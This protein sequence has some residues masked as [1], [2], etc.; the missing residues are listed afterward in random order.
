MPTKTGSC[1][2]CGALVWSDSPRCRL[3]AD[4]FRRRWETAECERCGRSFERLI[5]LGRRFC[6]A[7]CR[8][9]AVSEK[10]NMAKHGY[11]G[12]G[13]VRICE[14]CGTSHRCPPSSANRRYCSNECA[15]EARS[16]SGHH[17]WRG[18]VSSKRHLLTSSAKWGEAVKFVW[19]RDDARC[20][21]CGVRSRTDDRRFHVHHIVPAG[22]SL[23]LFFEHDNL[24]L[25]C[26]P[27]H[28]WVHSRRNVG[29]DFLKALSEV[30]VP[31]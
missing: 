9:A 5:S 26:E 8:R 21:R 7:P 23:E 4:K 20:Q 1:G 14:R 11:L 12:H 22:A 31:H 18:G 27:C 6:S 3:C 13:A 10:G 29:G 17:N 19:R 25:L 2:D 30:R 16:G 24:A 15:I 28:R